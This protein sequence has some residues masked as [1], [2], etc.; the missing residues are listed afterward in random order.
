M[1]ELGKP[2][3]WESFS[4]Y[5]YREHVVLHNVNASVLFAW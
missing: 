3:F 2:I 4:G 5:V 1:W